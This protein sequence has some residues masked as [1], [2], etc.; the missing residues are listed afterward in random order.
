MKKISPKRYAISLYEAT[1]DL[2]KDEVKVEIENFVKILVRN[3]NLK[4][5]ERVIEEFEKYSKEQEGILE[6]EVVSASELSSS[7]KKELEDKIK[8]INRVDKVDIINKEDDGL[9]GGMVVK[10][11]D[12]I[13]DASLKTRLALLKKQL[14]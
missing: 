7:F 12:T 3:K 1:Q 11:G 4:L 14:N 6:V 13:I 5:A 10:I 8:K 2:D 9:I